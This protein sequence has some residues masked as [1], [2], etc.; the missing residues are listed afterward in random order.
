MALA[1]T[2]PVP[3]KQFATDVAAF[4]VNV[5]LG[6]LKLQVRPPTVTLWKVD[7]KPLI[8]IVPVAYVEFVTDCSLPLTV[9]DPVPAVAA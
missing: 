4:D 2:M 3:L 6:K 7:V 9:A 5:P 8:L 1:E